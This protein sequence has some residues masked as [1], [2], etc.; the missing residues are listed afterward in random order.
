MWQNIHLSSSQKE[1][2]IEIIRRHKQLQTQFGRDINVGHIF[3]VLV[4]FVVVE[5]F[6]DLL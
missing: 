5:V 1:R 3:G 4:L 2:T 6:A